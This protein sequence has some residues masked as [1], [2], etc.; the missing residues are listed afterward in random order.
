MTV[1]YPGGIGD[2]LELGRRAERRVLFR[3]GI[4]GTGPGK[5]GAYIMPNARPRIPSDQAGLQMFF[6]RPRVTTPVPRLRR[7][8]SAWSVA[9]L[10]G[11]VAL[12]CGAGTVA[13]P[14]LGRAAPAATPLS[15]ASGSV[16]SR[17]P[18]E[19]PGASTENMIVANIPDLGGP[20]GG[21]AVYVPSNG[22]IYLPSNDTNLTVING[23]TNTVVDTIHLGKN[24]NAE[25]PTFVAA[26]NRLYVPQLG[27]GAHHYA[28][29]SVIDVATNSFVTNVTTGYESYP[30]TGVYSPISADLYVPN[31]GYSNISALNTTTD[32]LTTVPTGVAPMTPAYDPTNGY[33]YV[34]NQVSGN[35]TIIDTHNN[36]VV[37]TVGNLSF[38]LFLTEQLIVQSP[39]YDPLTQEVYV[40]NGN[41]DT[42][43][44]INGTTFVGNITVGFGPNT[45]AVA[46]NGDLYVPLAYNVFSNNGTI[47]VVDPR[48]GAILANVSTGYGPDTPVYDP[49]NGEMYVANEDSNNATII[50]TTTNTWVE[51]VNIPSTPVSPAFDPENDELYFPNYWMLDGLYV[52]YN[53]TVVAG[54]PTSSYAIDESGLSTGDWWQATLGAT[55]L[56]V[57]SASMTFLGVVAGEYSYIIGPTAVGTGCT[58]TPSSGTVDASSSEGS[59]TVKFSCGSSGGGGGGGGGTGA[60]GLPPSGGGGS[61]ALTTDELGILVG[62]I[63][64]VSAIA[65]VAAVM[66]RSAHRRPPAS[67]STVPAPWSG[68][69]PPP[70]PPPP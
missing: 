61:A 44:V 7:S 54:G 5:F 12:L 29:V 59:L 21:S 23:S 41:N 60:P 50:N 48:T 70:P 10:V 64:A 45:P 27:T 38:A 63:A 58:A 52:G 28:N 8:S 51:A 2:G 49:A 20:S 55:T 34:P 57:T 11:A 62:T 69:P 66:V 40:P 19:N 42:L 37:G 32:T 30:D 36:A 43:S 24:S 16:N 47:V 46:P 25:T 3:V 67:G 56:N 18:A 26:E 14:S 9:V 6:P 33:L 17:A 4:S 68:T 35:L 65:G 53:V 15:T 31:F 39:V 22:D 1:G 13:G